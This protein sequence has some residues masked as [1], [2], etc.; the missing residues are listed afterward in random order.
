LT[1]QAE[2]PDSTKVSNIEDT[3]KQIFVCLETDEK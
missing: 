2:V 3:P 1:E